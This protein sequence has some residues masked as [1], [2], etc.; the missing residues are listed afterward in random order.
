M[1]KGSTLNQYRYFKDAADF[2]AL[3]GYADRVNATPHDF[4]AMIGWYSFRHLVE[5]SLSGCRRS[6]NEGF[7]VQLQDGRVTNVGHICGRKAFGE[8]FHAGVKAI[9]AQREF[10]A[11]LAGMDKYR[12]EMPQLEARL[13]T[14]QSGVRGVASLTKAR[15]TLR[16]MLPA[17]LVR[18]LAERAYRNQKVVHRAV[19]R[20][21]SEIEI[22]QLEQPSLRG[23]A[24]RYKEE[25]IGY[26]VGIAL[27]TR[28][29]EDILRVKVEEPLKQFRSGVSGMGVVR[30]K[31]LH[32]ALESVAPGLREAENALEEA[33]SFFHAENFVLMEQMVTSESD[34][35]K[36]RSAR[37]Q[38]LQL[39]IQ[40]AA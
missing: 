10:E 33:W 23:D 8:A 5:C 39:S 9:E 19:L 36:I 2:R 17:H 7:V 27:F 38:L 26:F 3:D 25:R 15:R 32:K 16:E 40:S 37:R 34:R 21:E 14:L 31:R 35:T 12:Q 13:S 18:D 20:S 29:P 4:V 1:A 24:L 22:A 11:V 6:H 28:Y 30:L